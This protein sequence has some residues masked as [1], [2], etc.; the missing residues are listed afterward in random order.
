MLSYRRQNPTF[1]YR[2]GTDTDPWVETQAHEVRFAELPAGSYRFEV[3]GEV[4]PGV[5]SRPALLQFRIRA[6]WFLSWPCR[7]SL[8]FLLIGII[9]LWWRRREAGQLKVRAELEVAVEERTRDLTAA[10][11]RAEQASRV[12]SEF[13]ANISHEM[14]TPLNAVIGFTHLALQMAAQPEVVEYLKNVH[15]SAKGLLNLINDILDF[16]K[17]ESGRVEIVPVA[18]ALRPFIAEIASIL[19][20]EALRKRLELKRIIEDSTP[21]VVFADQGRLRQVL[22]NLMG[23]AIK[24]TSRGVV[25]LQVSHSA[26]Q[27][28]F[29]VSDTGI[30]IPPDKQ[31]TIFE[32][33][34]QADN[35]TSR[36]YGGTGLGLTISKK[37]VESMGG[38]IMLESEPGKGSTFWFTIDAPAASAPT[39]VA[40]PL[41][42]MSARPMRILVAEDNRVNQ[43]LM[44]AL[45]RKRGHTTTVAVNGVEALAA[46]ERDSFDLVFMDIQMPEMDGLEAVRRIRMAEATNGLRLPVVAMTARAMAGDREA[47]LAA[48]MDDYLEKPIQMERLDAVL[49]QVSS[50]GASSPIARPDFGEPAGSG[51][52]RP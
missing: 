47:I 21:E 50:S 3:Q 6:P 30:G 42:E 51:E 9:W 1:R 31:D 39:L 24:F 7:V 16:S 2:I 17:M 35:S 33:F 32:A 26:N 13:V 4:Q 44:L 45:L 38:Q 41:E 10:R 14:R 19:G 12:K 11:A 34:Q 23:N 18:F 48:G 25:T 27:L 52:A 49:S 20:R 5:W 36:R 40:Q 43:H 46:I 8:L 22:V 15:L 37:L 28:K 29:A